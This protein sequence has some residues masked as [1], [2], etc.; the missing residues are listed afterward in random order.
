MQKERLS[1]V[2]T[3]GK[4]KKHISTEIP[5]IPESAHTCGIELCETVHIHMPKFRFELTTSQFEA[6]ANYLWEAL[7]KWRR[8]GKPNTFPYGS[9]GF[10][11]LSGGPLPSEPIY[12]TRLEIEQHEV[13]LFHVHVRNLRISLNEEEFTKF[14]DVMRR[15]KNNFK[16]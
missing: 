3:L 15:A 13:P 6:F 14:A 7:E 1:E 11:Q 2:V 10:V 16:G 5:A 8:L 12:P 9:N 4:V